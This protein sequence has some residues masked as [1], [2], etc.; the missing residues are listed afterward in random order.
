MAETAFVTDSW[1]HACMDELMDSPILICR[2]KALL[3]HKKSKQVTNMITT[4]SFF[5]VVLQP[6]L[7][8]LT[9]CFS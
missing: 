8:Y 4:E 2:P 1:M 9:H 5:I 3:G 6:F 7:D